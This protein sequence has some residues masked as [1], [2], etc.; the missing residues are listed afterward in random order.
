VTD[1]FPSLDKMKLGMENKRLSSLL[2][3][4]LDAVGPVRLS[5]EEAEKV[6]PEGRELLITE[7]DDGGLVIGLKPLLD[8]ERSSESGESGESS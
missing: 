1:F 8:T 7:M 5:K 3:A 2:A 6:Q 4:I